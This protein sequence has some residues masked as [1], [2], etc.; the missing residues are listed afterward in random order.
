MHWCCGISTKF[1]ALFH[2]YTIRGH[3]RSP[4][5]ISPPN[6]MLNQALKQTFAWHEN[7][8]VRGYC[9]DIMGNHQ[10]IE[11]VTT[12]KHAPLA[13]NQS[14]TA[15]RWPSCWWRGGNEPPSPACPRP[16]P[17]Q[18]RGATG[19]GVPDITGPGIP[20]LARWEAR[21]PRVSSSGGASSG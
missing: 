21:T 14:A 18:A 5:W 17:G 4:E 15:R 2:K 10:K 9:I 12:Y 13:I 8:M 16:A 20:D 6:Y 11:C 1:S 7:T 3:P 19:P